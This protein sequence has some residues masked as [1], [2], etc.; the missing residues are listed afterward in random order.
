MKTETTDRIGWLSR[1]HSVAGAPTAKECCEAAKLDWSIAKREMFVKHEDG[2]FER[3]PDAFQGVRSDTKA[4]MGTV[5]RTYCHLDNREAFSFFDEVVGNGDATYDSAGSFEGGRLV[6]LL[7]RLTTPLVLPGDDRIEQY[8][9]MVDGKDGSR[10]TQ[11][12][13]TA[14]RISCKNSL[15]FAL[16]K[17]LKENTTV[18]HT[19]GASNRLRLASKLMAATV[20]FQKAFK[21]AVSTM[22]STLISEGD[23]LAYF[24]GVYRRA[25]LTESTTR[26]DV[27][28][29][30][31]ISG[32][33]QNTTNRGTVWASL[34]AVTEYED[35]IKGSHRPN[36]NSERRDFSIL[37]GG[38][39]AVK[40]RAMTLAS[41]FVNVETL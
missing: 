1:G 29:E 9:L 32:A 5:G 27:L 35:H 2:T 16:E 18:R 14:Y 34:N 38:A 36:Q 3:C 12:G 10:P 15:V 21:E 22:A 6:W 25:D 20:V 28:A 37:F 23:Q 11:V 31:A 24:N 8:I 30:L 26:T 7:A 39:H 13:L 33:G 19:S 40:E 4:L 17:G 41:K